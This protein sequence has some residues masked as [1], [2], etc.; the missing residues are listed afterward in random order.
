[1]GVGKV[2]MATFLGHSVQLQT[3]YM[4]HVCKWTVHVE[5]QTTECPTGRD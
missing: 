3:L 4:T 5:K 2:L 1:M